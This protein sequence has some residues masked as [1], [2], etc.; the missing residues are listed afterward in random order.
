[1]NAFE[2]FFY[3]WGVASATYSM[4]GLAVGIYRAKRSKNV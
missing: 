2:Q 1:M 4:I 3:G